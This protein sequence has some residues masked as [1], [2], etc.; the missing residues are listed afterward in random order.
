MSNTGFRLLKAGDTIAYLGLLWLSWRFVDGELHWRLSIGAVVLAGG[1]LLL[2]S[3]R[4]NRLL[5][6]YFDVLSRLEVVI[7]AALGIALA[8]FA[9][10]RSPHLATRAVAVLE[11]GGWGVLLLR[12]R[13]NRRLFVRQGHGPVPAGCWVSPPATALEPGDLILTSGMVAAGLRESVGH[14]ETVLRL[15]DGALVSFTS[16]MDQG[17]LLHDVGAFTS[18]LRTHGHY[19]VLRLRK[20]LSPEQIRQAARIAEEMI[21][22]NQRWAGRVNHRREA[23]V[24]Q[25]PLPAAWKAHLGRVAHSSGYDWLGLFMGRLADDRWTC[26]GACLELYRRLGVP[27][28]SYGTGLLGFGTTLFDPIM[29]VRFLSDPSF[30]LLSRPESER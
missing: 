24:A 22:A 26:I 2:T 8:L 14:G 9:L 7:P 10:V 29:P 12:Y 28:Q 18:A 15:G 1:W 6:T 17:A 20:E 21:A 30:R 3:V 11:L 23:I 16:R 19:I 27:T 25:L 5:A 13:H 4:I